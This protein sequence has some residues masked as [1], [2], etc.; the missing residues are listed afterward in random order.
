M[1]LRAVE[2]DAEY[3]ALTAAPRQARFPQR[4]KVVRQKDA[5]PR[6]TK[7]QSTLT[8]VGWIDPPSSSSRIM[9]S[10][11]EFMEPQP[12][13][14]R[15]TRKLEKPESQPTYTQAVHSATARQ[16]R[17]PRLD[18]EEFEM[19]QNSEEAVHTP[20]QAVVRE[21]RARAAESMQPLER[22]EIVESDDENDIGARL[23]L[24]IP[25][26]ELHDHATSVQNLRAHDDGTSTKPFATPQKVRFKEIP[27]SQSPASVKL[28]TQERD[29]HSDMFRSPLKER[30]VN[31]RSPAKSSLKVASPLPSKG[32]AAVT[33][34][35]PDPGLWIIDKIN[36]APAKTRD[37]AP[38]AV[39]TL[40]RTSTVPETQFD[41]DADN[42]DLVE[43]E[44]E[45][46]ILPVPEQ[47]ARRKFQRTNTIQDSQHE[48]SDL[49]LDW[50]EPTQH[51][52]EINENMDFQGEG[53]TY[54]EYQQEDNTYDPAYSALDRDAAR[55]ADQ[56]QT[57]AQTQATSLQPHISN[58]THSDDEDMLEDETLVPFKTIDHEPESSASEQLSNELM[59][60]AE[61][62]PSSQPS[63]R[64]NKG[65]ASGD[66]VVPAPPKNAE[67]QTVTQDRCAGIDDDDD[68]RVPS[69]PPPH[70]PFQLLQHA[71]PRIP[72][73][74]PPLRPSQVSTVVPTQTSPRQPVSRPGEVDQASLAYIK[75]EKETQA[76]PILLV[77]SPYVGTTPQKTLRSWPETY[78]TSSPLPLPPWSSPD[79]VRF[80]AAGTQGLSREMGM[81]SLADFSLPPPPLL[82]SSSGRDE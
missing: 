53:A 7:S 62:V 21:R 22:L 43:T 61:A 70:Q 80:A 10:E 68:E 54:S 78:A 31:V 64:N 50:P 15:I 19:W 38:R 57:Q 73:S 56:I 14:R 18:E 28:S 40:R 2:D 11:E 75:R 17:R 20:M 35:D 58:S 74:P 25:E 13:R 77:S 67:T 27:S 8:Q 4:R 6:L 44:M 79:R 49:E 52:Q 36:L 24:E 71:E 39:R 37:A 55:F 23:S 1:P 65:L 30:S 5:L 46:Q 69:S 32:S 47:R 66:C 3:Q 29:R 76:Q 16:K 59:Q 72:S 60:A 41:H 82:S 42:L 63:E 9:D 48:D 33:A 51:I 34:G 12:K 45:T 26:S 81:E